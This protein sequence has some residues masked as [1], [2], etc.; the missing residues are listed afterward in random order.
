MRLQSTLS[1]LVVAVLFAAGCGKCTSEDP[2]ATA[3]VSSG[4]AAN[5]TAD[6]DGGLR[7]IK[8]MGGAR[9]PIKSIP[10]TLIPMGSAPVPLPPAQQ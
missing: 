9:G 6:A 5:V 3:P 1:T 8:V 7:R 4:D 10:T 2:G